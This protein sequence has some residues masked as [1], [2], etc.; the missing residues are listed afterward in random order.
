MTNES[1]TKNSMKNIFFG[2]GYQIII[3]ILSFFSRTIFINVLGA[4]YLGIN[5]LYSNILQVLSLADLGLTSAMTFSLYRPLA[6]KNYSLITS[7]MNFFTKIYNYIALAIG[8]LGLS[9]V[10][11]LNSI[12]NTNTY[13]P[14]IGIFYLLFLSNSVFSY[15]F[16]SKSTI[17]I[18]DQRNYLIKKY[19]L[20]FEVFKF[21]LQI[22]VLY[23]FKSYST[24][25]IIQLLVT[26]IKNLY[27]AKISNTLY[28][29]I[30]NKSLKLD[31][32]ERESIFENVKSMFIYR[33]G[34]VILNNTDNIIISSL[35]G[36]LYVGLYSN[37]LLIVNGIRGFTDILFSSI[38]SSIGNLNAVTIKT[39]NLEKKNNNE[40]IY[41]II[42]FLSFWIY[43]FCSICLF[44][45]LNDFISLWIGKE[46][47]FNNLEV[48][49]IVLN[50]YI[51]GSLSGTILFRDTTG[52]FRQTKF[53][54]MFTSIINLIL[55]VILGRNYGLVG[56]L[57]ATLV[58]RLLT[59][60]WYEPFM[61]YKNYFKKSALEYFFKQF[62]YL[63]FLF[64]VLT[65][66]LVINTFFNKL[67]LS[68]FFFKLAFCVLFSNFMFIIF[69]KNSKEFLFTKKRIMYTIKNKI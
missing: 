23:L 9:L 14:N 29:F 61:L 60:V 24:Y 57:G 47:L 1:R 36:T 6:E 46:Y 64:L 41:D 21:S 5:G 55:S 54:F 38:A 44:V 16:I 26:V 32:K 18:A 4:E 66:T 25:L 67:N 69:Y 59:N 34:G 35:I 42:N 50:F 7:L 11:F 56:I 2:I 10:P 68:N 37:Y 63:M 22:L 52:L 15:L 65:L 49:V 12:V 19:S 45:L 17:I 31:Y 27:I 13:I 48:L 30:K 8:I 40:K 53:I 43:G 3:L 51:P 58:S 39:N 20:L 62:K 33:I 28:P